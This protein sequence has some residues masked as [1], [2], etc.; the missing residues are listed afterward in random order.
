MPTPCSVAKP[1]IGRNGGIS[2]TELLQ[3]LAGGAYTNLAGDAALALEFAAGGCTVGCGKSLPQL[4]FQLR[5]HL[6][7]TVQCAAGS[8]RGAPAT[9]TLHRFQ[10][11]INPESSTDSLSTIITMRRTTEDGKSTFCGV[12]NDAII[13]Q[14]AQM[15]NVPDAA[16]AQRGLQG[17]HDHLRRVPRC[18]KR[19]Q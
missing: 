7:G 17:L 18:A 8:L 12:H 10:Q 16:V 6:N 1:Y 11:I 15:S 9:A 4:R 13:T 5:R 3:K 19:G 2:S 14:R